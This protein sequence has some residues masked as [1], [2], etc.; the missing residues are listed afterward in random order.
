MK[1][2]KING[3][4]AIFVWNSFNVIHVVLLW[5]KNRERERER[6][7]FIDGAKKNPF[8]FSPIHLTR[9]II[10]RYARDGAGNRFSLCTFPSML[11]TE[12]SFPSWAWKDQSTSRAHD[13]LIFPCSIPLSSLQILLLMRLSSV[14]YISRIQFSSK[15]FF[16]RIIF[17]KTIHF[18]LLS[19]KMI[20]NVPINFLIY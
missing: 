2:E 19:S 8:V 1:D 6:D 10:S 18:Q 17:R 11:Q 20:S 4:S 13:I 5:S 15:Q 14:N 3:L 12:S 7:V 16:P 9:V